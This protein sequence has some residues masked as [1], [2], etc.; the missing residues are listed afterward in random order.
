MV[1]LDCNSVLMCTSM[2]VLH[3]VFASNDE[4]V[5]VFTI[6][7]LEKV[8]RLVGIWDL[9]CSFFLYSTQINILAVIMLKGKRKLTLLIA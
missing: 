1:A 8:S 3:G 6:T 5:G 9:F 4:K 2:S 7:S